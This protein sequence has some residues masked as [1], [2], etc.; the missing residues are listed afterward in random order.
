MMLISKK[1]IFKTALIVL[2]DEAA[3]PIIDSGKYSFIRVV[4]YKDKDIPGFIKSAKTTALIDLT[5]S[6]DDIFSKFN[7][8]TRN[9]VRKTMKEGGISIKSGVPI[10][11][12][13]YDMYSAF[14][15]AQGRAPVPRSE[16]KDCLLFGVYLSGDLLSGIFV[17]P[18]K[19]YL[20][21]RSIFSKRLQTE[22]KE[23][24]KHISNAT[25][26]AMW[27]ICLWGKKEGYRSLDLA[28]VNLTNPK[29]ANITKFK[30][31]FGGAI[32]NEYTYTYKSKLFSS[33][34][35]LARFRV[36]LRKLFHR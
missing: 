16:L 1:F 25:R 35:F 2:E 36:A 27:E 19:P 30:M 14:E 18:S 29:T 6:E 31:S 9:E 24:Y 13:S 12:A 10:D 34:E 22:D 5:Q 20:R 4:S 33:L 32:V 23:M 11:D 15:F 21:I 3:Q 17:I 26:R 7:D 8:T 28:S